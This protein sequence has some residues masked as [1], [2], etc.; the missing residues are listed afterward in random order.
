MKAT[1]LTLAMFCALPATLQ[2]QTLLFNDGQQPHPITIDDNQASLS[3]AANSKA[4]ANANYLAG[5]ANQHWFVADKNPDKTVSTDALYQVKADDWQVNTAVPTLASNKGLLAACQ[6]FA[7]EQINSYRL[8]L[9][10]GRMNIY[11]GKSSQQLANIPLKGEKIEHV[12]CGNIDADM[13]PE[14][15]VLVNEGKQLKLHIIAEKSW[16]QQTTWQQKT[17]GP[18]AKGSYSIVPQMNFHSL[19]QLEIWHQAEQQNGQQNGQQQQQK[20]SAF[21]PHQLAK[22]FGYQPNDFD[23]VWVNS[24]GLSKASA[25]MMWNFGATSVHHLNK[26]FSSLGIEQLTDQT[27]YTASVKNFVAQMDPNQHPKTAKELSQMFLKW[28]TNG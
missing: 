3:F 16:Q 9:N 14:L 21:K 20:I 8:S 25:K 15:L 10:N 22:P 2:A 11:D 12:L 13:T 5:F 26:Y 27:V 1:L 24:T 6:T 19:N 28:K 18:S 4:P 23:T 17:I 7:S